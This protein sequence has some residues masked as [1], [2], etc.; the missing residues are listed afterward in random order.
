MCANSIPGVG[1]VGVDGAGARMGWPRAR[2]PADGLVVVEA[3]L[4]P[5]GEVVH[6]ALRPRQRAQGAVQAV[7]DA[8]RHLWFDVKSVGGL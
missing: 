3:G 4:V 8:L 2:P 1:H 6:G 5:K 7:R